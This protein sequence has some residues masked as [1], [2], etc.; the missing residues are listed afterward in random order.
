MGLCVAFHGSVWSSYQ[1]KGGIHAKPYRSLWTTPTGLRRS[2]TFPLEI[3]S[4]ERLGGRMSFLTLRH[5][6]IDRG[7]SRRLV[8]EQ[9]C[10]RRDRGRR[11]STACT[12]TSRSG[13]ATST[14]W[15]STRS[16]SQ[17]RE[18]LCA[19]RAPRSESSGAAA[20]TSLT[21]AV[22]LLPAAV[23][24]L[25]FATAL[26]DFAPPGRR[27]HEL[28]L[29]LTPHT[30]LRADH[31]RY[32]AELPVRHPGRTVTSSRHVEREATSAPGEAP[33]PPPP[34]PSRREEADPE[35][36]V[37]HRTPRRA[38]AVATPPD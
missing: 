18:I 34:P 19:R 37:A 32:E 38:S 14:I 23:R 28:F 10:E 6:R 5:S 35:S 1:W 3:R 12:A 24:S 22:A 9:L 11:L 21:G 7:L 8:I 33:P 31:P 4:R 20:G 17:A 16:L 2:Q 27:C 36:A 30:S 25:A 13:A 15:S 26:W 29:A